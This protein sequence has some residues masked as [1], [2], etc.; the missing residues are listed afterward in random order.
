MKIKEK[1]TKI[2]TEVKNEKKFIGKAYVGIDVHKNSWKVCILGDGGFK[3]EF[4]CNPEVSV[5]E[6]SLKNLL[7]KFE[8]ECAYEAGFSGFWLADGLNNIEGFKCIVVN[9]ADIPTSDK[10]RTQKEDRRDARKIAIHL[11]GGVLTGIYIPDASAI[12]LRELQ[13]IR[14]TLT[15]DST[16]AKVR[17]KSFLMRHGITPPK[18]QFP[19]S[20]NHWSG[21]FITWLNSLEFPCNAMRFTLNQF[22]QQLIQL[23]LQLKEIL[24]ELRK[25]ISTH[26]QEEACQQIMKIAGIGVVGSSTIITEIVDIKRFKT[27]DKYHSFIGLVPSTN[28]SA[29]IEKV[30]GITIRSNLRLRSIFVESAWIAIK[31]DTDLFVYYNELKQRMNANKAIIRVA[32]KLATRV[33]YTLLELENQKTMA[34]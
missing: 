30:R 5:L 4:S 14:F 8:F 13:R 23:R 28:S 32:K 20:R 25:Q 6:N 16:R 19:S 17:I 34:A 24:L 2:K 33:R 11:K 3:K 12:G 26:K 7:P 15:K 29:D 27:Y 22:V 21:K 18:E 10:E 9:P 1:N 31:K